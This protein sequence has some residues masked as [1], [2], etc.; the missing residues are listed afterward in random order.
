ME[1][2]TLYTKDALIHGLVIGLIQIIFTLIVYV[3]GVEYLTKWWLGVVSIIGFLILLVIS[4]L[5]FRKSNNGFATLK[6]LFGFL[7]VTFLSAYTLSTIFNIVLHNL[8][9]PGLALQMKE[10]LIRDTTELIE[11][12]GG[13][14][15]DIE[16]TIYGFSNFEDSFKPAQQF[17]SIVWSTIWG[18]IIVL[19]ISAFL[20]KSKSV[21]E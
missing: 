21:F 9:D 6:E 1:T 18:G 10:Y 4:G 15:E 3:S 13:S 17:M 19:I 11:R 14:D 8:I 20:K 16:K 12:F 7:I 2:E 5:Q